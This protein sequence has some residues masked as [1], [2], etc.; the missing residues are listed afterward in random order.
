MLLELGFGKGLWDEAVNRACYLLNRQPTSSLNGA[1]SYYALHAQHAKMD[2][3]RVFGCRTWTQVPKGKRK[4][5]D[6][7]DQRGIMV[8]Y[9][10]TN[11]CVYRVYDPVT[12]RI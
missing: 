4:K 7:K 9:N 8:G 3:L 1:T 5:L 12:N 6:S 10:K 11:W 2:H